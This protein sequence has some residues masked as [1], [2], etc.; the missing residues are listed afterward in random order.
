MNNATQLER[1]GETEKV[2]D[3]FI[4]AH[5]QGG[6]GFAYCAGYMHSL[7]ASILPKLSKEQFDDVIKELTDKTISK[8]ANK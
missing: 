1:R 4:T 2:L 8:L 3:A 7:L 6:Q 5:T